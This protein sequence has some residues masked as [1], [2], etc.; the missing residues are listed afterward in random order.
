MMRREVFTDRANGLRDVGHDHLAHLVRV[1]CTHIVLVTVY[2]NVIQI[3]NRRPLHVCAKQDHANREALISDVPVAH[4]SNLTSGVGAASQLFPARQRNSMPY[5]D[6][7]GRTGE[8]KILIVIYVTCR[9]P[10]TTGQLSPCCF[11]TTS[12]ANS[13]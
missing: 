4:V 6:W 8:T 1:G 13:Q 2:P 12:F 5:T 7:N 9:C 11:A 3:D 10:K